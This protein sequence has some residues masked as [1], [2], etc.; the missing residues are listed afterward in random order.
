MERGKSLI[1]ACEQFCPICRDRASAGTVLVPGRWCIAILKQ[2]LK[3][4]HIISKFSANFCRE[5][6]HDLRGESSALLRT[7]LA[8][9]AKR[10]E[11]ILGKVD[12]R[13]VLMVNI[14][15]ESRA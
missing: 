15:G 9:G 2:K 5:D 14:R 11:K 3:L 10:G 4:I 7:L 8:L 1:H 13:L 6:E 12:Y